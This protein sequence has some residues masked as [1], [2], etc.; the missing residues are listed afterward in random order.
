MANMSYHCIWWVIA[1]SVSG[2]QDMPP[3]KADAAWDGA[4]DDSASVT[5]GE[6]TDAGACDAIVDSATCPGDPQGVSNPC[7]FPESVVCMSRCVPMRCIHGAWQE[8][9]ESGPPCN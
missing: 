5:D 8:L 6:A 9:P 2:C 4:V 1:V 3:P 7:C